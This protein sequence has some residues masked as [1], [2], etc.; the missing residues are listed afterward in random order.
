VASIPFTV[1][2]MFERVFHSFAFLILDV[3]AIHG[4]QPNAG[5]ADEQ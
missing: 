2:E 1:E 4:E 5:E 3:L